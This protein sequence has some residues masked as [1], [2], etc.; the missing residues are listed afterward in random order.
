MKSS[1]I[2]IFLSLVVIAGCTK[3]RA[4]V[5]LPGLYNVEVDVVH[6]Y[7]VSPDTGEVALHFFGFK[8]IKDSAICSWDPWY[9]SNNHYN[10]TE[11]D[12]RIVT[13]QDNIYIESLRNSDY[14]Q[15]QVDGKSISYNSE[16]KA[17]GN[18][19]CLK[20]ELDKKSMTGKWFIFSSCTMGSLHSGYYTTY[21]L[22]EANI[23][24]KKQPL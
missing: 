12:V 2:L 18:F 7:Q 16:R 21:L 3:E 6:R 17:N 23:I 8:I 9:R 13:M 5:S 4:E 22:E 14:L 11:A 10:Y 19:Q 20:L 15:L 1:V 24:F